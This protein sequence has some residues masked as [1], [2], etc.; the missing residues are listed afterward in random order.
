MKLYSKHNLRAYN[1]G[2]KWEEGKRWQRY[3]VALLWFYG[4]AMR[5]TEKILVG[6]IVVRCVSACEF[7][8]A[9]GI[10]ATIFLN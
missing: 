7:Q 3:L 2:I 10:I 4:V 8:L 9:A 1:N 5:W 6:T